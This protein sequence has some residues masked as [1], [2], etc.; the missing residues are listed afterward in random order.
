M[1]RRKK[2]R[3]VKKSTRY[4]A[5]NAEDSQISA[6]CVPQNFTCA[7]FSKLVYTHGTRMPIISCLEL[8]Y[9]WKREKACTNEMDFATYNVVA[10]Q[11][12]NNN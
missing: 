12:K 10:E 2:E 9:N 3:N 1:V 7:E 4:N 11:Q 5:S 6:E 8:I